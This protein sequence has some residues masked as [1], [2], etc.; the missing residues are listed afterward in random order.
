MKFNKILLI[1]PAFLLWSGTCRAELT[2]SDWSEDVFVKAQRSNKFVILD[3]EAVWCHWCHVMEKTTYHDPKVQA[4]I[5][6]HFIAVRVDQDARPD[7]SIRYR[8]YGWPATIFFAADGTEIVK[9]AG[10]IAPQ[11]MQQLLQAIVDD[12][13]PEQGF[14]K[15]HPQPRA[16]SSDLH[17]DVRNE[18]LKRH[19]DTYDIQSGSLKNAQKFL[20]RDSVEYALYLASQGEQREQQRAQ[21]TLD[22]ALALFDPAWGGVYQ[23]STHGDWQHPHYEKIMAVQA[24]YMRIYALA[25]IQFATP[26]YR[27]AID[28]IYN[29]VQNFLTSPQGAFYTS[30]D[31][32]LIPGQHSDEYFALNDQQRR[33]RG[34]PRVDKH[35]YTQENAW[36]IE[37]LALAYEA[38]AEPR[39]LQTALRAAQWLYANRYQRDGIYNH[40]TE[41]KAGPYLG[42]NLAMARAALALYRASGER[43]WLQ[44]A[45]AA[46][47]ALARLFRH[48]QAGFYSAV[49]NEKSALKPV[50]QI[51]QNISVT[52]HFN[53]IAQ[54]TGNKQYSEAARHA[55]QYLTHASV[56]LSRITEAGI[57]LAD[58]ELNRAP[59][60]ITVIG[61]KNDRQAKSLYRSALR[62]NGWYKRIEWW[63]TREGR[64]P[65]PDVQYPVLARAAAFVC[66]DS[67][68][69][70]PLFNAKDISR[71]LAAN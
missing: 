57:L 13:S 40:D 49:A 26:R 71:Q 56:A 42:D 64:L 15:A 54:F 48:P 6:K 53:L 55:M 18:L 70:L 38:T 31:A 37:A 4:L 22:A 47:Q 3:L 34:I 62:Q 10:Y 27:Q 68:C 60:H 65:N 33:A 63:D 1:L 59:L 45:I 14:D 39:Y 58:N 11:N 50:R 19:A 12:P 28:S 44:R 41:D 7:L 66:T 67:R 20:E 36:M 32:D 8:D 43:I 29:Y 51:D 61:R 46:S 16:F 5:K 9:R 69:S 52:R 35:R 21:Q 2:W 25:Y 23:Y 24:G 30:Q 17:D